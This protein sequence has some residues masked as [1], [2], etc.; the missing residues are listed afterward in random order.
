MKSCW[1][2]SDGT[3]PDTPWVLPKLVLKN[4]NHMICNMKFPSH[5]GAGF[6][7]CSTWKDHK[8]PIG[9]KSRFPC[10]RLRHHGVAPSY[11]AANNW[12]LLFLDATSLFSLR[13]LKKNISL[14][15][16]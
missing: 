12:G 11:V 7:S 8:P 14:Q 6:R 2:K 10:E 13:F 16:C 15:S 9:F 5:Y 3:M 4:M 1:I